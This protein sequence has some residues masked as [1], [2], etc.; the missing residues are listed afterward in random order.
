M[1]IDR[2]EA[3]LFQTACHTYAAAAAAVATAAAVPVAPSA[4]AIHHSSTRTLLLPRMLPV[5]PSCCL[6]QRKLCKAH[7]LLRLYACS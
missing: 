7:Q 1:S 5:L 4:A 6:N 3:W 2:Q